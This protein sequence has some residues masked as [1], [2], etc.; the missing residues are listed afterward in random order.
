MSIVHLTRKAL[1]EFLTPP[2]LEAEQLLQF[3]FMVILD[4]V[5]HRL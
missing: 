4:R 2:V 1:H 3:E 5:E